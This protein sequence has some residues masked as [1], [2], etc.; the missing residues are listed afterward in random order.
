M[1]KTA[2]VKNGFNGKQFAVWMGALI[3]G[4]V[5]G[6][7]GVTGLNDF[8]DFIATGYTK[9]F[10]FVA[11]PTIA[12]AILT[13][14]ASLGARKNTGRIFLHTIIYT[15]LT[16]VAAAA[17]GAVLFKLVA[18]LLPHTTSTVVGGNLIVLLQ[19]LDESVLLG[20][21]QAILLSILSHDHTSPGRVGL[22]RVY[23]ETTG[24]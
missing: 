11:V 23:Q 21:D 24:L 17:V 19:G 18:Q 20:N 8:F 7:L 4:G 3:L 13:T 22:G 16:T 10:Q 14:L 5:L 15:L 12:L 2:E 9:L 6:T 1:T